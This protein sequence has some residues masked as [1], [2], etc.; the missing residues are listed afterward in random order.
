M[1]P[2]AQQL[3]SLV[4][5]SCLFED[6]SLIRDVQMKLP[7]VVNRSVTFQQAPEMHFADRHSEKAWCVLVLLN[8]VGTSVLSFPGYLSKVREELTSSH[9]ALLSA[10]Q[11]TLQWARGGTAGP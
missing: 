1:Y 9:T 6:V 5:D 3:C 8:W 7:G 4:P 2:F 10:A 11:T